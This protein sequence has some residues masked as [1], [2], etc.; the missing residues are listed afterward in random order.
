MVK[1]IIKSNT[2]F[3]ISNAILHNQEYTLEIAGQ[4]GINPITG[5]L[6]ED[7]DDQTTQI[8]ENIKGILKEIDWDL[9]NIIKVVIY[10]SDMKDY[11]KLNEIYSKFFTKDYPT[12]V[13]IA[14]KSLPRNALIEIECTASGDKVK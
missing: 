14:V 10:L 11:A 7:I 5:E 9:S 13:A 8:F 12:R 2:T 1:R 4:I 6:F 3:P